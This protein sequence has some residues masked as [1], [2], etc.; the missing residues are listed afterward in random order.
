MQTYN[1]NPHFF[2]V[3]KTENFEES[4][5]EIDSKYGGATGGL[6]LSNGFQGAMEYSGVY[7]I[8]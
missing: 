2:Y 3:L 6:L 5:D 8:T 4:K 7:E 1:R